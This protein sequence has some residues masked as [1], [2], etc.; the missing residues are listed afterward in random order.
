MFVRHGGDLRQVRDA[1]DL[2][3][4]G[5]HGQLLGNL[6][7]CPSADT[8]IDLVEDERIDL[9]GMRHDRFDRKHDP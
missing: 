9:L 7:G 4:G 6:L 2:R 1:D 3:T 8:C 5:Y